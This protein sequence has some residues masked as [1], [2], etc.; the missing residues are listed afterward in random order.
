MASQLMEEDISSNYLGYS[1]AKEMWDSLTEMYSDLGNQSQIYELQLKLGEL[2]QGSDTATKYFAGLKR[3]WQDL[4]MYSEYTWK[5]PVDGAHY[6]KVV[7][8]NRV[9]RFLAGLNVEFDDVIGA[10]D[11]MTSIS[12]LFQ[13]YSPCPGNQKVW[14]ADGSLSPIAGKGSVKTS[15]KIVLK[16]VLHVPHLS[17]N[18][19]SVSKLSQDSNCSIIFTPTNCVFQDR[20]LGTMIG[21]ARVDDD[22]YYFEDSMNKPAPGLNC[23]VSSLPVREQIM[24]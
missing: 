23:D 12:S 5:D 22:L 6:Q 7:D 16:S 17:C 11:H 1:T 15:D 10:S 13:T 3:L 18:L 2:K 20:T 4:D 21:N 9:F 24:T 8:N 19:L 14:I